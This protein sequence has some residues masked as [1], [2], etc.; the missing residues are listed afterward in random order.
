MDAEH[1]AGRQ[2][3]SRTV[4]DS[5][6]GTVGGCNVASTCQRAQHCAR[7][8]GH[9][10]AYRVTQER[11]R[12]PGGSRSGHGTE[13]GRNGVQEGGDLPITH[14]LPEDAQGC[15]YAGQKV[16]GLGGESNASAE[17]PSG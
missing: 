1:D 10:P 7:W 14:L 5:N 9:F 16:V 13:G 15:E 3:R 6:Q 4:A 11:G 2:R 12:Q 17:E 8:S